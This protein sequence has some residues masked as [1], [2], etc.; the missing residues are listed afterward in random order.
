[1][2]T[3][4]RLRILAGVGAL[5]LLYGLLNIVQVWWAARA[6]QTDPVQAIVVMGAAQYDGTPSPALEARLD[7]AV[8]LWDAGVAPLVVVTGGN[9]PGDRFTEATAS[10][11]YLLARGIPDEA[12]LREVD[13]TSSYESLAATARFLRERDV[14][15]VVL[16]SEPY[17]SFR[18][19]GIAAEVGLDAAVS[20][21]Q[22]GG[23]SLR[24]LVRESVAVSIGRLIGYRRLENLVG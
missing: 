20:P 10:A 3:A 9:Q 19:R 6:D 4:T 13:G 1:V 7:H 24:S 14:D 22:D 21:A 8:E 12:I 23:R 15:R 16:V 17:H 11:D 18:L 5:L 2:S